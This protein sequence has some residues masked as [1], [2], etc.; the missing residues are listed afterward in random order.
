MAAQQKTIDVLCLEALSLARSFIKREAPYYSTIIYGFVPHFH[1]GL[2]TLGVSK[3]MSLIVDPKWYVNM[4]KEAKY[5]L[6][7]VVGG[8]KLALDELTYRMQAGVLVHEAGHILRGLERLDSLSRLGIPDDIINK[9]FDLP[10]NQ[11]AREC[12]WFLPSWAL[13]PDTYDFPTN[14]TGEQYVE[15]LMEMKEKQPKKYEDINKKAGVGEG[16]EGKVGA[17]KC[18]GCGGNGLGEIEDKADAE[19]GRSKSDKQRI[20]KEALS[21][22]RDA[23]ASGRGTVPNSLKQLLDREEKKPVVPWRSRLR[24]TI[25][26]ATGQVMSG[27]SD[28]SLRRPSKRSYSRGILRPG[29]IDKKPEIMFIE[30]SSGS[31]GKDQLLSV[32]AEIKGVF[33]QLG[34]EDAWF[35]DIDAKVAAAPRRIRLRDLHTLPVHGRGGTNFVP[36][37]ELAQTMAPRPDILIYLTDGDGTAPRHAPKNMT[38]VWCIVPT[39]HGRRPARWGELVLVSNDQE[40]M[41]P[42]E[43]WNDDDE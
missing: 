8:K 14:L 6:G 34:I 13:Y 5:L 2:G 17:G 1:E 33:N 37:I 43:S 32:R 38:V 21:Q 20:R 23:V 16:S 27:R 11:D 39:P 19:T 31:M 4:D 41:A 9:G 12:G 24:A 22:V 26:R 28:F 29:M 10:I 3:G 35:C 30:D 42:Y 36:G 25:R 18:G 7:T 40:L 15:L